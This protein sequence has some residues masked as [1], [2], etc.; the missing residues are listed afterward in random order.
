MT[1]YEVC[2][3]CTIAQRRWD[4][5][6]AYDAFFATGSEVRELQRGMVRSAIVRNFTADRAD[7]T[8]FNRLACGHTVFG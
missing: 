4:R 1:E 5:Q 6:R 7:P 3:E 2:P 8:S